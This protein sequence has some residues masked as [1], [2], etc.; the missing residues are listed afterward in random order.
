MKFCFKVRVVME[1]THKEL[2]VMIII[3]QQIVSH[4]RVK[5]QPKTV[6][7]TLARSHLGLSLE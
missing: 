3:L 5:A 4:K 2:E 6:S 1:V 7:S